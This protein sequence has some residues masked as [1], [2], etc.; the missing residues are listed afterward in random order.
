[1]PEDFRKQYREVVDSSHLPGEIY[2]GD[3]KFSR[4]DEPVRYGLSPGTAAVLYKQEGFEGVSVPNAVTV[5]AGEKIRSYG[6]IED[7]DTGVNII[8][9]LNRVFPGEKFAVVMKHVIDFGV[10]RAD[11]IYKAYELAW[12]TDPIIPFGGVLAMNDTVDSGLAEKIYQTFVDGI[13]AKGFD[14]DALKILSKKK[15]LRLMGMPNVNLNDEQDYNYEIK[16]I[17]GGILLCERYQSK[18]L[19]RDD[20]IVQSK[21]QPTEQML[22]AALLHWTALGLI[23]SNGAVFGDDRVT[24]GVGAGQGAR[25]YAIKNALE[26]AAKYGPHY[27]AWKKNKHMDLVLATDG[28]PPEI[29]SVEACAEHDVRGFISPKGSLKDEPVLDRAIELDLIVMTTKSNERP[30]TH[31]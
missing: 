7:W 14:Q 17:R 3:I 30:F 11:S 26:T 19:K 29:D 16:S 6:N 22:D 5:Q 28:F 24:Y 8:N 12:N 27:K 4:A 31:R 2:V 25:V 9:N 1:M 20:I 13:I 18:T 10:A 15:D 21:E 23:R